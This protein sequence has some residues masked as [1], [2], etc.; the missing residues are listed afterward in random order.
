MTVVRAQAR[1]AGTV[2]A[3]L[4]AF[5][6]E[7]DTPVPALEDLRRRFAAMLASPAAILL[8]SGEESSPRGFALVTLRPTPYSDG[9]LAV[10]DELYVVPSA[11]GR[12]LGSE[13]LAAVEEELLA[14]GCPELHIDVDEGDEDTRRFY[15]A[16]GYRNAEPWSSERFLLYLKEF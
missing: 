1:H 13:L 4:T 16:H 14:R 9:P 10:L 7:F 5:N 8:L 3:L 6:T 12:G 15:V 2:A 11:R